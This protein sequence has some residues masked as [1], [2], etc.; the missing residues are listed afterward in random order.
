MVNGVNSH[1]Q[2]LP[3][4][5]D[6]GSRSVVIFGG[7]SVGERKAKLFSEFSS[8]TVVSKSF[9]EGLLQMEKDGSAKLI[10]ADLAQG[11]HEYLESAFMV[12]PATSDAELNRSIEIAASKK[13]IL[14]NKVDGIGDVVVPSLIRKGPIAIAISTKSP[15]LSKYLR[16]RLESELDENFEGMARLLGQIRKELKKEVPDQNERSRIIWSILSDRVVWKLLNL[17]YEKAYMRA[18]EQVP[19]HERDSLDAGDPPQGID[20]RD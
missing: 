3:L 5:L 10:G 15:A 11:Y 2:L 14:V 9:T 20:R 17:S 16:Q 19:Q 13:G 6:L 8:V 12:I 7:G 18:R 4:F 1:R